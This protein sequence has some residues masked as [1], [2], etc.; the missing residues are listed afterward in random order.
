MKNEKLLET[1]ADIAYQAGQLKYFSG[2]SRA[3]VSEFIQW[4]SQFEKEN[5]KTDWGKNDYLLAIEN[6]T[7]KKIAN[8]VG[9]LR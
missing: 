5:Q 2:D 3:D 9:N 1:V 7:S 4:A 6:F 8:V